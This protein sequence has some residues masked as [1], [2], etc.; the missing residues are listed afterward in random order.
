MFF[1]FDVYNVVSTLLLSFALQMFFFA[2]AVSFKTDKLTDFAYGLS[3]IIFSLLVLFVEKAYDFPQIFVAAAIAIWG[4]RL[5]GYLFLRILKI[6]KDDRFDERRENFVSFLS[7][8][9]LQ[10]AT[11]W[12]VFLPSAYLL[13][14]DSAIPFSA[15]SVVGVALWVAGFVLETIADSQKFAFKSNPDNRGRWIDSGLW[16]YSRHPNYFGESLLWWGIFLVVAPSLAGVAWLLISGP[17]FITLLLLFVSGIPLLEKSAE[18]KHGANP[19]YREY[20]ART[21]IF[22]ILPKKR[23]R[24]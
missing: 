10:A 16:K 2:F 23:A 20:K 15:V 17:I 7:F 21:S 14:L 13:S 22:F 5:G 4:F 11:V 8:W 18:A 19:E 6:G 24:R 1:S 12:I 3:F 9:L